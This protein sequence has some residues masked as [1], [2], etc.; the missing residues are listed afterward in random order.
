MCIAVSY[1]HLDVYK[2][3]EVYFLSSVIIIM[4]KGQG[5]A[6]VEGVKTIYW[7]SSRVCQKVHLRNVLMTEPTH[8]NN[9]VTSGCYYNDGAN[10][11]LD[12]SKHIASNKHKLHKVFDK[13]AYN[14]SSKVNM[15]LLLH[16]YGI[17]IIII[18]R[19]Y[20]AYIIT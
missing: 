4:T 10:I 14:S 19:L 17:F 7:P 9:C 15:F 18:Y 11:N 6:T 16:N 20:T 5:F 13:I 3:Q 8:W 2:R 1:T 12:E